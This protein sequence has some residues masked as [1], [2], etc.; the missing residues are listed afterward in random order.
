MAT[1]PEVKPDSQPSVP[2]A[3]DRSKLSE[4][5][6][7]AFQFEGLTYPEDLFQP[8]SQYGNNYMVFYINVHEDSQFAKDSENVMNDEERVAAGLA[9]SLRDQMGGLNSNAISNAIA[10]ENAMVASSISMV[11]D[12]SKGVETAATTFLGKKQGTGSPSNNA[13]FLAKKLAP[14]ATQAVTALGVAKISKKML[15]KKAAYKTSR[16][17]IALYIPQVRVTYNT[18]WSGDKGTQLGQALAGALNN[19]QWGS[20]WDKKAQIAE[21][22]KTTAMGAITSRVLQS[23]PF[24]SKATG[25]AGNPKKEQV[26]TGVEF[27]EHI[28]SFHFAP[29]SPDEAMSVVN[30]IKAFKYHMHPEFVGD[31]QWLYIYPSE[32]DI[33][34]YNNGVENRFL[35]KHTSSALTR[36]DVTY[37]DGAGQEQFLTFDDTFNGSEVLSGMPIN[38]NLSMTFKELALL[39]KDTVAMGF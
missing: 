28:F 18:N 23:S 7:S 35:P 38:I 36:L 2:A 29:R 26:F 27:R 24:A 33:Y 39:T 5:N 12:L 32:F 34:Y 25:L 1:S 20:I 37:S 22:V 13:S 3:P 17:A 30:I 21:D 16:Q 10:T 6:A 31:R 11:G 15:S 14:Y 4:L 19:V 9:P 8:N